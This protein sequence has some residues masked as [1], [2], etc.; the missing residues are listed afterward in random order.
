M[1]F[2]SQIAEAAD[3]REGLERLDIDLEGI[4]QQ[5]EKEGVEKFV[6]PFDK[7]Q[8]WLESKRRG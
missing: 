3:V 8:Q 7:L 6:E 2:S 4:A 1:V 5:L